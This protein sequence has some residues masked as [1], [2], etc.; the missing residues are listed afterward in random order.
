MDAG[1]GHRSPGV[2]EAEVFP[3]AKT[4]AENR[5]G[6][7]IWAMG[8]TQHTNANAIVRATNILMLALGNVGRSGSSSR[9]PRPRQRA[10][11]ERRR[12]GARPGTRVLPGRVPRLVGALGARSGTSTSSG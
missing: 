9:R 11:C 1:Q 5:P 8:Q 12:A 3:V 2:P 7:I 4:L 6:F 10:G